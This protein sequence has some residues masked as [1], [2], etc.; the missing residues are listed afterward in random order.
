V[1][2]GLWL[3]REGSG[4]FT[5]VIASK[6][7]PTGRRSNANIAEHGLVASGL[8]RSPQNSARLEIAFN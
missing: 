7:V 3:V 2:E 5:A 6:P 8:A 4:G 1:D